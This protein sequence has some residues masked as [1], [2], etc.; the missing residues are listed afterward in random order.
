M[1]ALMRVI[2]MEAI[3]ATV[4]AMEAVDTKPRCRRAD[5]GHGRLRVKQRLIG[6]RRTMVA[7]FTTGDSPWNAQ[8]LRPLVVFP[9][10]GGNSLVR[11]RPSSKRSGSSESVRS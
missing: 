2:R 10:T 9:G 8:M 11:L 7:G 5:V 4:E 6:V 3:A 1:T